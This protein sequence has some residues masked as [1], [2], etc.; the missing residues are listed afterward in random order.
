MDSFLL[1][2]IIHQSPVKDKRRNLRGCQ[3][4]TRVQ[5]RIAPLLPVC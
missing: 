3:E 2:Q 4:S 5:A 1:R